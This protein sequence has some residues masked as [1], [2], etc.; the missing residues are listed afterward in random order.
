MAKARASDEHSREPEAG[1]ARSRQESRTNPSETGVLSRA[2]AVIR[3]NPCR[4]PTRVRAKPDEG[5][6]FSPRLAQGWGKFNP[7]GAAGRTH[8]CRERDARAGSSQH[9]V[10]GG[11]LRWSMCRRMSANRR[12]RGTAPS[13][14]WKVTVRALLTTAT[15]ISASRGRQLHVDQLLAPLRHR[16]CSTA[17][18]KV[19]VC[20][21][22]VLHGIAGR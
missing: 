6:D 16:P 3:R 17:S 15:P 8:F 21:K 5:R 9:A 7:L 12:W 1:A 11:R 4:R 13:A 14:S 18:S 10:A 19:S 20:R 2:V 22:L